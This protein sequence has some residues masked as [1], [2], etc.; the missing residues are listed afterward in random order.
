MLIL[1]S[2]LTCPR[3]GHPAT[4]TMPTDACQVY[5]ECKRCGELLRPKTGDC[6]VFCSWGNVPCPPAQTQRETEAPI[7]NVAHDLH[8][9]TNASAPGYQGRITAWKKNE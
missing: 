4:E 2:T 3:C 7:L 5:Y 1:E 8:G 9:N 6:C